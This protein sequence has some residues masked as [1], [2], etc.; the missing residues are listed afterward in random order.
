MSYRVTES[1][2]NPFCWNINYYHDNNK[3]ELIF[4]KNY[5]L[6]HFVYIKEIRVV[7]P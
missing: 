2:D 7:P 4:Y 3:L 5:T 1:L 6:K